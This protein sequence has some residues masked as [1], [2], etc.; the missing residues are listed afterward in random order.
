VF[1]YNSTA[2][3]DMEGDLGRATRH[4][5]GSRRVVPPSNIQLFTLVSHGANHVIQ[6]NDRQTR[7]TFLGEGLPDAVLSER[8]LTADVYA[9]TANDARIGARSDRRRQVG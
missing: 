2:D 1:L 4:R 9:W 6:Q 7:T 8:F 3:A 5:G